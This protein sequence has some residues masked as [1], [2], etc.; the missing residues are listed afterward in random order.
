METLKQLRLNL[1]SMIRGQI[2][3]QNSKK[4]YSHRVYKPK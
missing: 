2:H 4:T 3:I 1:H